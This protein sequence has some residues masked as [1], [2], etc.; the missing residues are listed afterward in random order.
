MVRKQVEKNCFSSEKRWCPS[1]YKYA[2]CSIVLEESYIQD[3][4]REGKSE[5]LW[6]LNVSCH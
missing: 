1:R 4:G 2:N 5:Y 3:R 6:K